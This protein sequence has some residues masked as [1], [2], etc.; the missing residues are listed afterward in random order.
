MKNKKLFNDIYYYCE[1]GKNNKTLFLI[2]TIIL[3]DYKKSSWYSEQR[4]ITLFFFK[5][6]LQFNIV[7]LT[8][9]INYTINNKV[10]DNLNYIFTKN[11]YVITDVE[12]LKSYLE[13]NKNLILLLK[14]SPVKHNYINNIIINIFQYSD[15]VS[16]RM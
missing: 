3:T 15:F 5:Y 6:F 8:K 14:N 10:I 16:K 9:D 7:K 12:K 13:N 4:S 11:G 1:S 2:P